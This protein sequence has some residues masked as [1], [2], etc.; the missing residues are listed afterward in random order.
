[1][2]AVPTPFRLVPVES[3]GNDAGSS[4]EVT[5]AYRTARRRVV[6]GQETVPLTDL[7]QYHIIKQ[8]VGLNRRL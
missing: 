5:I 2:L 6:N 1:M 3:D 7:D 8:T 4:V